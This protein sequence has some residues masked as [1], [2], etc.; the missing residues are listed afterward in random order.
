MVRS[1]KLRLVVVALLAAPFALAPISLTQSSAN[2][3][4]SATRVF[5]GSVRYRQRI[6]L[7]PDAVIRVIIQDVSQSEGTPKSFAD[8]EIPAKGH[9]I[10]IKFAVKYDAVAVN[11]AHQYTIRAKI[12]S[13]GRLMFTS[14]NS[15]PVLT[16]GAPSDN[17]D[18]DLEQVSAQ[19]GQLPGDSANHS[20]E[21]LTDV[22]WTLAEVNGKAVENDAPQVYIKL[23]EKTQRVEGSGGCN[24][25]MGSYQVEGRTLHFKQT[26]TTMMACNGEVMDQERAFIG[27]LD[28][29]ESFRVHNTTL[30]LMGKDGK[31]LALLEAQKSSAETQP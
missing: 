16:Q 15:Y 3:P 13:G 8:Q 31:V 14:T 19:Y 12:T 29:T 28:A 6:A 9:Q 20:H 25:L 27:A 24:R 7:P 2:H 11:P 5:R 26:G 18:I 21:V 1:R 4:E 22:Q 17:V 30:M 10:P 23:V